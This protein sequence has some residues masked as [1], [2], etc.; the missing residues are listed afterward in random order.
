MVVGGLLIFLLSWFWHYYHTGKIVITTDDAQNTI[1]LTKINNEDEISQDFKTYT[2]HGKLSVTV[3]TGRYEIMVRGNIVA[4]TKSI[5]LDPLKTLKY[6][7][8][9]VNTTG[10]EPVVFQGAQD[11]AAS[12]SRLVYLDPTS[13]LLN[14]I[15]AQNN[16]S[17]LSP[18]TEFKTVRWADD[19]FGMGQ[20]NNGRLYVIDQ[21]SVK[22]LRLPFSYSNA[23]VSFDVSPNKQFYVSNGADVYTGDKSEKFRKIYTATTSDPTL[24]AGVSQVAVLDQSGKDTELALVSQSGKNIRKELEIEGKEVAWS[25]NGQYIVGGNENGAYVYNRSLN[26][27]AKVPV[28][29]LFGYPR[30]LDNDTLIYSTNDRLWRYSLS[31]QRSELIANMPM[32]SIITGLSIS[33]D[34]DYIYFATSDISSSST[35]AYAIRRVG[36]EGQKTPQFIYNLQTILPLTQNN[37]SIGLVN[38]AQPPVIQVELFADSNSPGQAALKEAQSELQQRGFDLSKLRFRVSYVIGD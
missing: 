11:I 10:V 1:S 17:T 5:K 16:L 12:K 34:R 9:P 23:A 3:S 29:G 7:I 28:F 33:N 14:K 20:D 25:P 26:Y 21:D 36:V 2:G 35:N 38:F 30:W 13:H 15:D 19:T 18:S 27:V 22:T 6:S 31:D 8:N 24:S 32:D 37:F 4:T